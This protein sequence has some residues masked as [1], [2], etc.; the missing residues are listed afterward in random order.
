[1]KLL[2]VVKKE[3]K[4]N[5]NNLWR[6]SGEVGSNSESGSKLAMHSE[7]VSYFLYPN[8]ADNMCFQDSAYLLKPKSGRRVSLKNCLYAE[9]HCFVLLP[10]FLSNSSTI[11]SCANADWCEL[12]TCLPLCRHMIGFPF[13]CFEWFQEK[14]AWAATSSGRDS[15]PSTLLGSLEKLHLRHV[16]EL[17]N[18][19]LQPQACKHQLHLLQV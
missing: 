18:L 3:I 7:C 9:W 14:A 6:P 15:R 19:L 4:Q 16:C 12:L 1:M 5:K 2:K 10:C 8:V 13:Q 11:T 17:G